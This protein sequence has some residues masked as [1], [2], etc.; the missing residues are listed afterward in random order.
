MTRID[1]KKLAVLFIVPMLI[2]STT[3]LAYAMWSETLRINVTVNTGEVDVEWSSWNCTDTGIDPGYTKN[4]SA[5]YVT[6]ETSDSEGDVIKLNVTIV[7]AYPSYNVTVYGEVDNI[8]TIPVK[9]LKAFIDMDNDGVF[10]GDDVEMT[11]CVVYD[12]DLDNDTKADVNVHLFL[13]DDG[14]DGSQID[15]GDSDFYGLN[16]HIKQNATELTTYQFHIVLIFAQ[17]NDA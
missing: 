15:P 12:L 3:G 17:W 8:G 9:F 14:G 6:N 5:C 4:V 1:L 13:A 11:L 2:L 16:I 7:N 10:D